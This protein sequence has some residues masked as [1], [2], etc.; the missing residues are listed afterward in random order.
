MNVLT[1]MPDIHAIAAAIFGLVG[2]A[3]VFGTLA[4]ALTW[5]LVKVLR[6]RLAPALEAALWSIVLIKFLVPI[7][8][9]SSFS[10]A[11]SCE[12]LTRLAVPAASAGA[13]LEGIEA[14]SDVNAAPVTGLADR[15]S[16]R[17]AHWATLVVATYLLGVVAL[18]IFRVRSYHVFRN[19]CLALPEA[20]RRTR[21]LV[22]DVCLRLGARRMPLV[23]IGEPDQAPLVAGFLR[24]ILVLSPLH[25]VRPDE[26]ETVIVHEVAHLRRGDLLVRCLQ[27]VA[28]TVLFFWPVVGWVSR[29]I[30]WAREHACDEWALRHGPLS[31]SQYARCL[32]SAARPQP[33][34]RLAYRPAC[35]AGNPSTIERRIDVI[36]SITSRSSR[37]PIRGLLTACLLV[38]WGGFTLTGVAKDTPGGEYADTWEDMQRHA[39]QVYAY[40]N[41]YATADSDGDGEISKQECWAFVA[42]AAMQQPDA[43]L[44]RY[45]GADVDKDGELDLMEAH[46]YFRG[47]WDLTHLFD[48]IK[49]A[50]E[51]ALKAGN[52][53]RAQSIKA[54]AK[55]KE[56]AVYHVALD[57]RVEVLEMMPAEPSAKTVQAL[58]E[59]IAKAEAQ[60][61]A[62]KV[63]KQKKGGLDGELGKIH[64]LK[65]KAAALRQKAEQADGRKSEKL[66]AEA[67]DIEKQAALLKNKLCDGLRSKIAKLEQAGKHDKAAELKDVLAKLEQG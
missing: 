31:A 28:G 59:K 63:K 15:F 1:V 13:G 12:R 33:S 11:A 27:C 49:Q 24:P 36:L 10:L 19:R 43:I 7:G 8:P 34:F 16:S 39:D 60:R 37:R 54:G 41:Q 52:E 58:S 32:L 22:R 9:S 42:I 50:S 20:D 56:M 38:A 17:P 14:A 64:E 5:L 29:R 57:R 3:L 6:R 40:I 46:D 30:D 51:K 48:K 53:E 62:E 66:L 61:A 26:V 25:F 65:K 47:D 4:A 55:A 23:R 2:H 21:A 45:P 18:T 44:K 67:D 35:M